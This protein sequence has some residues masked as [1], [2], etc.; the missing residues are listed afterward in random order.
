MDSYKVSQR[1]VADKGGGGGG[2]GGVPRHQ[3]PLRGCIVASCTALY[4]CILVLPYCILLHNNAA[5]W[6]CRYLAMHVTI[7]VVNAMEM[8]WQ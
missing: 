3:S 2:G 7:D 4:C 5:F 1:K 8:W 6:S